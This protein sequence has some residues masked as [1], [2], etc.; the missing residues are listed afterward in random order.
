MQLGLSS[1]QRVGPLRKLD[2]GLGDSN[3]G[4]GR[5]RDSD[6]IN[7]L[8]RAVVGLGEASGPGFW[9]PSRSC[10]SRAAGA[11]ESRV[12]AALER[13]GAGKSSGIA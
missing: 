1:F 5:R 6:P 7:C 2:G 10:R 13:C 8:R 11:P 9:T 3:A 12:A 4:C